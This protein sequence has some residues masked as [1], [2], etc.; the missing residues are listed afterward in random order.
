MHVHIKQGCD[1]QCQQLTWVY[2]DLTGVMV[3]AQVAGW[4]KWQT[5]IV[6]RQL[7]GIELIRLQGSLLH[8]NVPDG[9]DFQGDWEAWCDVKLNCGTWQTTEIYKQATQSQSSYI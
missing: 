9:E 1:Y 4:A 6:M 2:A 7:S 8:V 3:C 5:V